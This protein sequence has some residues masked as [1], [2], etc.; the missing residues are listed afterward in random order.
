MLHR[1][2]WGL[3]LPAGLKQSM[4]AARPHLPAWWNTHDR[5]GATPFDAALYL[6]CL[7]LAW[8][9]VRTN[10]SLLDRARR[11]FSEYVV[12]R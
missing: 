8:T 12:I 10:R 6:L 9:Q 4:L 2:L 7:G 3:L 11:E 1:R 5:K